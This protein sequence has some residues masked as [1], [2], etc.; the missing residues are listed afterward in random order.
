MR[1][2]DFL[3]PLAPEGLVGCAALSNSCHLS[4]KKRSPN[5]LVPSKH[6]FPQSFL[7]KY[8]QLRGN[9]SKM[10]R[11]RS[12]G[13]QIETAANPDSAPQLKKPQPAPSRAQ[14]QSNPGSN[15]KP[16][17]KPEQK[18]AA[19]IT[20]T[21]RTEQPPRRTKNPGNSSPKPSG[22]APKTA[23]K[24][25]KVSVEPLQTKTG[26]NMARQ[27]NNKPAPAHKAPAARLDLPEG[28]SAP[29]TKTHG[30]R[31]RPKKEDKVCLRRHY[32]PH[33]YV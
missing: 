1:N 32:P 15:P 19:A 28:Y 16:K 22:H 8:I 12:K 21:K 5:P 29:K 18:P 3:M 27:R 31:K 20:S 24:I 33:A 30:P 26:P 9:S 4:F 6:A 23:F 7:I 25:A 17:R 10:A 14:K 13:A 11:K 2:F